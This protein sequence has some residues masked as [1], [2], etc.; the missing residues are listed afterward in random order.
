[1]GV[2]RRGWYCTLALFAVLAGVVVIRLLVDRQGLRWPES[3]EIWQLRANRVWAALIV[4]AALAVSGV[5]LQSLLRNPL[6]SPDL[7]G[8]AAGAGLAVML[9]RFLAGRAAFSGAAVG[10]ADPTAAL[11]GSMAALGLVYALSQRRGLIEPVSLI[12]VGVIISILAGALSLLV[13]NFMPDGGIGAM[14]WMMGVLADAPAS[15]LRLAGAVTA[16]GIGAALWMARAMDA[17]ALGDDEAR[18]VGV[19]LSALRAGMFVT[20]GVLTGAA[21]VLSGPIGFVGLVCPHLVRLLVGPTHMPLII[22][23]A[24][25]GAALIIGADAA[26]GLVHAA[27]PSKSRLPIGV[28]TALIGGPVFI[29][30]LRRTLR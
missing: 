20:A 2:S 16:V 28:L 9:T 24:L 21:I 6:A 22:G 5:L 23:S 4:G 18:S 1:M 27:D 15:S 29:V 30:L 7:L 11:A 3:G 12:L 19:P 26:V 17:A 13:A 14:R 10:V 8:L 25:V